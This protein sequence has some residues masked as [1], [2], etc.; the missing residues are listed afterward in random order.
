MPPRNDETFPNRFVVIDARREKDN[1]IR[2]VQQIYEK[3]YQAR[4]KELVKMIEELQEQL[5]QMRETEELNRK[6]RA[7]EIADLKA[8]ETRKIKEIEDNVGFT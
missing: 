2:Q 3:K 1:Q 6:T 4:K 8:E 7:K 5:A